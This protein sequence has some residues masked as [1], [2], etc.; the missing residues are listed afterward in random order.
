MRKV[1]V[2]EFLTLDGVYEDSTAW[3]QAYHPDD[4]QFKFDE[5][6]ESDALLLGR[7]TYQEFAAYWPTQQGKNAF[8]DRMNS[9]PKYVASRTLNTVQWNASLLE[10]NGVEAVQQ[11]QEQD[12]QNI[13]MYGSGTLAHWLLQHGLVD[14][15]R[16]M[17]FPVVLGSGKRFFRDGNKIPLHLVSTRELGDGVLL[18]TYTPNRERA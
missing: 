13:L 8:A 14:E 16:L 9:L 1:V 7:V 17:I 18:L 11:L 4:G 10:G 15:L 2:T 3:Q 5:L 6:F 12:G